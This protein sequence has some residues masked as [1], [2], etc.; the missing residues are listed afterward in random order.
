MKFFASL[1]VLGA[2]F[3][4][5]L[6]HAEP[7]EQEIAE[8]KARKDNFAYICAPQIKA[9]HAMRKRSAQQ[10][11][12]L[13][14]A[15]DAATMFLEEN[16]Q[17]GM[18]GQKLLGCTEIDD[19]TT[20]RNHTC[21]LANEVTQG[22]YYHIAG[23]PI[24]QNMAE[25]QLGLP[26]YIDIG[27]LDVNTC[28]PVSNVLVD[29]WHANTTGHYAGHPDPDPDLIWEGPAPYG[30]R[31]GLL[32]KFPR[33]NQHETWL[34]AAWPTNKFGVSQFTSIFPGYYTG[35]AT[36]IHI[37]VHTTWEPLANGTFLTSRLI[38]TG[39]LFV[40]DNLNG[41][42]DKIHPYTENP[43]RNKWGRT[44]NWDDSLK[45]FQSQPGSMFDIQ[46]V[47]GV[48]QQGLRGHI[49]VGVDPKFDFD[50]GSANQ[51]PYTTHKE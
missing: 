7:T 1:L 41:I 5:V 40:E 37:K 19:D 27:I 39:Q 29:I 28:E 21:V 24:R 6:G 2:L 51:V 33:W 14:G 3:T 22:P 38:H 20:I 16:L 46:K 12:V 34:R 26:F 48:L 35:R 44:R 10:Q 13:G 4:S 31:K 9:Y 32:T 17:A 23:H 15:T 49:T 8:A 36:H 25:D 50:R 30:E 18:D 42:I 11:Q 47:G 43:I 45:I